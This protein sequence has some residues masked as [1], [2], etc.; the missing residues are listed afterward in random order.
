MAQPVSSMPSKSLA[1]L[2]LTTLETLCKPS[3]V[4][5]Q[6]T[7][8]LSQTPKISIQ[9]YLS[10]LSKTRAFASDKVTTSKPYS[11]K[12]SSMCSTVQLLLTPS[13]Y[14]E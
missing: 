9:L 8:S 3:S 6:E 4:C 2:F 1:R 10:I 7:L 14:N 5:K 13:I 11:K 12:V